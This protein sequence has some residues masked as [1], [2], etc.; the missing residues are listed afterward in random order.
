FVQNEDGTS[1]DSK[2]KSD[3][4]KNQLFVSTERRDVKSQFSNHNIGVLRELGGGQLLLDLCLDLPV[5]SKIN[6][7]HGMCAHKASVITLNTVSKAVLCE[8]PKLTIHR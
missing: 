3:Q 5:L 8:A 2:E 6:K 1:K 4:D 7:E